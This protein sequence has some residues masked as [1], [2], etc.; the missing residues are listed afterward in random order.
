MKFS[1][2]HKNWLNE[3]QRLNCCVLCS[4]FMKEQEQCISR[5][6][7]QKLKYA[8]GICC[9]ITFNDVAKTFCFIFNEAWLNGIFIEKYDV[10]VHKN[11]CTF[12]CHWFLVLVL[13]KT[14]WVY[15]FIF[16]WKGHASTG[17]IPYYDQV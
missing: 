17:L 15:S 6:I 14:W 9:S 5:Y 12:L 3:Y 7:E 13:Y 16:K 10:L 1:I 2:T 4:I 8:Q 11:R